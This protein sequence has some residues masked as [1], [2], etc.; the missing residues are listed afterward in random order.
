MGN[1]LDRSAKPI[2]KT[3]VV[4]DR[5]RTERTATTGKSSAVGPQ[6]MIGY[7]KKP[8]QTQEVIVERDGMRWCAHRR[9]GTTR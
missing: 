2:N 9:P 1:R 5:S 3:K 4:I 7:H 6:C 8:E